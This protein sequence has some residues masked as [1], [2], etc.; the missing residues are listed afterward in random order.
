MQIMV[1]PKEVAR[2]EEWVIAA[3]ESFFVEDVREWVQRQADSQA[4][5]RHQ[6][7]HM[8]PHDARH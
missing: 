6:P 1:R 8:W 5:R 2:G 4:R 3:N 7:S